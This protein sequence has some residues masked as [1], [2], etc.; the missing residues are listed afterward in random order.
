MSSNGHGD[1]TDAGE[2][3]GI[4]QTAGTRVV[5]VVGNPRPG[6]RTATAGARVAE[7]VADLIGAGQPA[8]IEL[9]GLAGELLV[10]EH[11]AADVALKQ[12]AG[13][14]VIVVATPVYKGSYTG[15]LKSFLDLYGG[16]ALRGVVAVPL[17]VS[18]SPAH[19]V[20]G[21]I[22]LRPVL[23]ELGAAVPTAAVAL[24]EPQLAAIDEAL[25][26]WFAGH[27]AVLSAAVR[28]GAQD[29]LAP[30]GAGGAR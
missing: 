14:D 18:A 15:L 17:V 4:G 30:A 1:S 12:V 20:A 24:L 21:E 10:R 19:S 8:V 23:L 11:P 25:D 26:G 5:V 2:S 16:G 27:A 13:A 9:A 28:H 7:R 29:V 6:S 3:T 22:H